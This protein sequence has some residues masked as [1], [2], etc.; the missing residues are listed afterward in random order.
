MDTPPPLVMLI[1]DDAQIR[2]VLRLALEGEGFGVAEAGR[3]AAG[4]ELAAS[5]LPDLAILDLG[6]PDMDGVQVVRALRSW[7]AMPVIILSARSDE[8]QKVAA[9]DA[10]ADDYLTKPFGNSEL[11]A[12]I[13]AHLRRR[14]SA[15]AGP[16]PHQF[17]FGEVNVDFANRLVSRAGEQLHLTPTEFKLLGVLIHNAG[18][19]LTHTFLLRAVWGDGYAARSHYLRIYMARLRQKLEA[20]PARPAHIVTESGVGY[21]LLP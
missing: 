4:L 16:T 8:L 13:R 11:L 7:S 10:G 18:K 17:G 9:L 2:R 15:A 3:G 6:L 21:R 12:R 14:A 19:V 5:C 1:E 20:D